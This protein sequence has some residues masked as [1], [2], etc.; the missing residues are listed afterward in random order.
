MRFLWHGSASYTLQLGGRCFLVDPHFSRAGD[1]GAWYVANLKAPAVSEYLTAIQPDWVLI[2]HSHFDHFDLR[3]V[4]QLV[5][6]SRAQF[7][8]PPEVTRV[9]ARSFG[10]EPQRL[11][12]LDPGGWAELPVNGGQL[13]L[14]AHAGVHWLTGEEGEA[15]ALRLASKRDVY[16]LFP[17]GGAMLSYELRWENGAGRGL[18]VYLTGDTELSGIPKGPVRADVMVANVGDLMMH[19]VRKLP[20]KAMMSPEEAAV[21]AGWLGA[22][23]VIPVHWDFPGFLRPLTY[24]V[25]AARFH[26]QKPRARLVE[27][28]P[29]RWVEIPA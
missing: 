21:A 22:G 1:Y 13:I 7:V 19:P 8:G 29:G 5:D 24:P 25:V 3:T 11:W 17:C 14:R 12:P 4:R 28:M 26:G 20:A 2:T 15:E 23:W 18:S 9:I 27:P 10:A 6:H 16:G